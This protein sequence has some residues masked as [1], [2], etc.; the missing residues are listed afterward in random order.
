MGQNF[1][2]KTAQPHTKAWRGEYANASGD[3]F[4]GMCAPVERTLLATPRAGINLTEGEPIHVRLVEQRVLVFRD[5]SQVGEIDKPS[6]DVLESLATCYGVL[7]GHVEE[8]NEL[9]NAVSV[10]VGERRDQ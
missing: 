2:R 1:A 6:F 8:V 10:H 9:A 7:D 5:L 3:L 4:A